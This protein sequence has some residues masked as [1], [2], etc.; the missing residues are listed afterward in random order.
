MP[1]KP[2]RPPPSDDGEEEFDPEPKAALDDNW[3]DDEPAVKPKVKVKAAVKPAVEPVSDDEEDD[4]TPPVKLKRPSSG[5]EPVLPKN[6]A[7]LL[8]DDV[9]NG[10]EPVLRRQVTLGDDRKLTKAQKGKLVGWKGKNH[11]KTLDKYFE[12]QAEELRKIHGNRAVMRGSETDNLII[13][14]PMP[15]LSMEFLI[16]QDVFPLGLVYHL[17]AEHGVGKSA[18]LAEIYRWFDMAGGGGDHKEH[19]TK[20]NPDWYRSI[21]GKKSFDRLIISRCSSVEDWQR[22]LTSSVKLQK[23]LMEGTKDE[24]GPGRTIPICFGVDSIMGKVSEEHQEKILGKVSEK[25]GERGDTGAGH[26]GRAFPIEALSITNYL[27]ALPGELDNWPFAL[28]LVNHLKM[29]KD[30]Q[31]ND[32]RS[33]AGGKQVNFQESFELE[34]KKYGGPKANIS[35]TEFDGY[36]VEICCQKN[37]FGPTHR[38]ILTRLLWWEIEDP[39]TGKWQQKTVWD[40]DWSTVHLL[41]QIRNVAGTSPRLKQNLIDLNFHIECLQKAEKNAHN[42]AWSKTLGMKSAKDAVTWSELGKMIREHTNLIAHL[43]KALRINERP[44]LAGDYLEQ[45]EALS[46]GLS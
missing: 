13:G 36:V 30:D 40:W 34:L 25:T 28:V 22:H 31:G 21:L 39:N 2:R 4:D 45:A 3:D 35:S 19:E 24:P 43:R 37:S 14:I 11:G 33:T 5:K 18:F 15:A 41:N 17:V 8:E 20:W 26:A 12:R 10:R 6:T 9:P 32:A 38:K 7:P 1:L 16:A 46:E 23:R 27:K 44:L 42:M 29:R